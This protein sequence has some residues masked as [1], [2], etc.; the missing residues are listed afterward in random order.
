[1]FVNGSELNE[2]KYPWKALDTDCSFRSDPF[3]NMAAQAILISDW[4]IS[5][6]SSPLK[7]L[8]QMDQHLVGSIL[9]KTFIKIPHL[10]PIRLQTWRSIWPS[11][12]RGDDF[13]RN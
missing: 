5:K 7:P 12:F 8:S 13:F 4:L 2:E 9:G 1:M 3:T 10:V 6:K 11:G